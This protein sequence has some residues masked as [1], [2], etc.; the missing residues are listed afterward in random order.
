MSKNN[1]CLNCGSNHKC[2]G[3]TGMIYCLG[4]IGA[5]FY[6]LAGVSGIGPILMGIIK[7][8]VWPAFLVFKVLTLWQI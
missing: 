7:A 8:L 4:V 3:D 2:G 1:E 5:L 6:F